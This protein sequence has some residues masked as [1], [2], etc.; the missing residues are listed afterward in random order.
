MILWDGYSPKNVDQ[1][2]TENKSVYYPSYNR[3]GNGKHET[4]INKELENQ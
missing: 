3:R 2:F 1:K 4:Q